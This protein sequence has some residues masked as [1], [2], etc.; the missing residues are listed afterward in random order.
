MRQELEAF[1]GRVAHRRRR[2]AAHCGRR[3]SEDRFCSRIEEAY[4]RDV[5]ILY[6]NWGRSPN[7]KHQPP[8]PGV[9]LRRRLARRFETYLVPE[10]Y[11]SSR[12]PTCESGDLEKPRQDQR[13]RRP[14]HHLLRCPN[15]KCSCRWWHRDVLGA[16][17]ILKNGKAALAT[18]SWHRLF[19]GAE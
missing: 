1:Y 4:G 7:L 10:P 8:S 11:T 5:V 3:S 6:G 18:G 2:Y 15:Q 17:N 14:V 13:L 16:L 12:C 19:S 9:G